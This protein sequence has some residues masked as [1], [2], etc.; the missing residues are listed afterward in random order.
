MWRFVSPDDAPLLPDFGPGDFVLIDMRAP[1]M[2]EMTAMAVFTI[3]MNILSR[4]QVKVVLNGEEQWVLFNK[5][6]VIDEAHKFLSSKWSIS[7]DVDRMIREMRHRLA[8]TVLITHDPESL[9]A[10]AIKFA[11]MLI[12]HRMKSAKSLKVIKDLFAGTEE[13]TIGELAQ[14]EVGEARVIVT[15]CAEAAYRQR[16][17]AVYI[18]PPCAQPWGTTKTVLQDEE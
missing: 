5:V 6:F 14:Q 4:A 11:T 1:W 16:P 7:A 3:V 15:E 13:L 10:N 9:F 17:Q 2:D 18:R 8:T 12:L